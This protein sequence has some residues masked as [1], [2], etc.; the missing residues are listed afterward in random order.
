MQFKKT[1]NGYEALNNGVKVF[2]IIKNGGSTTR[3]SILRVYDGFS[4]IVDYASTLSEAKTI[5]ELK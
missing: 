2:R 5:C 1:N 3:W 4:E